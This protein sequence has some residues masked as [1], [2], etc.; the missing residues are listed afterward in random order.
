MKQKTQMQY[1]IADLIDIAKTEDMISLKLVI[2]LAVVRLEKEKNQIKNA[3]DSGNR[4]GYDEHKL[5][6]SFD[7][8]EIYYQEV[9]G[10]NIEAGI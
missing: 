10:D 6:A 7:L 4:K 5:S 3:Y 1:L 9:F 2:G 8:D